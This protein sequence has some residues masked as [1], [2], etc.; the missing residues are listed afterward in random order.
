MQAKT[1][2]RVYF[3]LSKMNNFRVYTHS[4]PLFVLIILVIKSRRMKS[5]GMRLILT[6]G[7]YSILVEK[8]EGKR[9][10]AR[11]RC[12]WENDI[13]MYY[14]AVRWGHEC[15]DLAYH[16]GKVASFCECR[17]KLSGF[18]KTR[19]FS[20]LAEDRFPSEGGFCSAGLLL[21]SDIRTETSHLN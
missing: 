20:W 2:W 15:F 14:Q 4:P 11:P 13:Q 6:R 19:R 18:N 3:F 5:A 17:N 16:K 9:P 8:P 1:N 21:V 7:T 12:R 10:L